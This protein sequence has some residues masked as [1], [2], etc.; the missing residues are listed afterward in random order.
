MDYLKM[1]YQK[2]TFFFILN[3]RFL[4]KIKILIIHY[5]IFYLNIY[6]LLFNLI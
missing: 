2:L 4:H 5:F 1:D 3:Y 6:I